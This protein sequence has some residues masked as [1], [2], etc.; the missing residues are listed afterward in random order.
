MQFNN[1]TVKR[2]DDD[3]IESVIGRQDKDASL[4]SPSSPPKPPKQAEAPE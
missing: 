4:I 2:Y 3:D 1:D